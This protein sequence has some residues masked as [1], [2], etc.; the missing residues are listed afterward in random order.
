MFNKNFI[1]MAV[2]VNVLT[3]VLKFE[4]PWSTLKHPEIFM[5]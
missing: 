4:N 3:N 2:N 1:F 5:I